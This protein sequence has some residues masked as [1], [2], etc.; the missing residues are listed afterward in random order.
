MLHIES[1]TKSQF[2]LISLVM[3]HYISSTILK[4]KKISWSSANV[5]KLDHIFFN[6]VSKV[7]DSSLTLDVKI[8]GQHKI[9]TYEDCDE[10]V[11]QDPSDCFVWI[12]DTHWVNIKLIVIDNV[13]YSLNFAL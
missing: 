1:K 4:V 7:A 5:R 2:N 8:V 9:A 3:L 10:S 11:D 13:F 6:F 12:L